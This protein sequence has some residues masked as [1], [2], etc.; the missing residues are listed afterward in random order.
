MVARPGAQL[1]CKLQEH[2]SQHT[3]PRPAHRPPAPAV[4]NSFA[5]CRDLRAACRTPFNGLS[6][7]DV[8]AFCRDDA[9]ST[10]LL[11]WAQHK[12]HRGAECGA[13]AGTPYEFRT[14][15]SIVAANQEPEVTAADETA[16]M[17]IEAAATI[18]AAGR[19]GAGAARGFG[20]NKVA[21]AVVGLGGLLVGVAIVGM[22]MTLR[23]DGGDGR[24]A[25]G[26]AA[27][28]LLHPVPEV[29]HRGE[30]HPALRHVI[31]SN[32]ILASAPPSRSASDASI[33]PQ[34]H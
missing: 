15:E 21:T 16:E 24:D 13:Y 7:A 30:Q 25:R 2:S 9:P 29:A 32:Y 26:D 8:E 10:K 4:T 19:A 33:Q 6:C 3:P 20:N 5:C 31:S 23:G 28:P 12:L 17:M 14:L 34:Q 1:R 11:H 27:A 22:V 18:A